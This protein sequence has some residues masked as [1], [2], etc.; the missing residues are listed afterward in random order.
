MSTTTTEF[1]KSLVNSAEPEQTIPQA[2][3][4][5]AITIEGEST[6]VTTTPTS[7]TKFQTA[8]ETIPEPEITLETN[9]ELEVSPNIIDEH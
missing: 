4:N 7:T 8:M 5:T 6:S 1:E 2:K 9:N 3:V